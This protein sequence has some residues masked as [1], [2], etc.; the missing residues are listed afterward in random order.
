MKKILIIS[1][2]LLIS[3]LVQAQTIGSNSKIKL[4]DGSKL[5][6]LIIKNIPGKYIKVNLAGSEEVTIDYKSIIS[7]KHYNYLYRSKFTLP[8]GYFTSGSFSFVSGHSSP[9]SESRLGIALG[10]CAN[11]R[12]NSYASLGLGIEPTGFLLNGDDFAIPVFVRFKGKMAK[13]RIAP[14]YILD[15]GWAFVV[16]KGEEF[17]TVKGGWFARPGYGLQMNKFTISLGY[18][19]Q[20]QTT[21]T[22]IGSW[23]WGGWGSSDRVVVEKRL[24]KN[25]NISATLIF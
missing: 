17:S 3:P 1:L 24:M 18:Q 5:R 4:T 19:L 8:K 10:I 7:I 16:D 2:F 22:N 14:V 9:E 11:Y 21:T 15:A 6:V 23:G 12:F 20:E 25:I 13:K